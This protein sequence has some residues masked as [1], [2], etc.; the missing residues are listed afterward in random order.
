MLSI[1]GVEHRLINGNKCQLFTKLIHVSLRWLN[2]KLKMKITHFL[3]LALAEH[4]SFIAQVL[5]EEIEFHV[6]GIEFYNNPYSTQPHLLFT[7]NTQ[8]DTTL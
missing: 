3:S 8:E 1:D 2:E 5:H 4:T 6:P 7:K